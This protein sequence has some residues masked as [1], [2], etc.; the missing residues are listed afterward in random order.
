[1]ETQILTLPVYINEQ[2]V[3]MLC[4]PRCGKTREANVAKFKDAPVAPKVRCT[5]GHRFRVPIASPPSTQVHAAQDACQECAG[6]G[7]VLVK[8]SKKV[9]IDENGYNFR[10]LQHRE[11]CRACSGLGVQVAPVRRRRGTS[12]PRLALAFLVR[13]IL[14]GIDGVAEAISRSWPV[15]RASLEADLAAV[16]KRKG[17]M[18]SL[19]S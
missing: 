10:T 12:F 17:S 13:G 1:M 8:Q 19:H 11:M 16:C 4:C 9:V 7:F 18:P 6:Q 3:A 14:S 2:N 5:C 15:L